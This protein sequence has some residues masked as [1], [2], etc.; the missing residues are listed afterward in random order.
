MKLD[1]GFKMFLEVLSSIINVL[2][3]MSQGQLTIYRGMLVPE[4]WLQDLKILIYGRVVGL[5]DNPHVGGG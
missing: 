3:R 2:S 5:L 4:N 1:V